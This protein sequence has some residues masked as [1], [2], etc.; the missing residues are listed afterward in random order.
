M[1]PKQSIPIFACS[2]AVA[3]LVCCFGCSYTIKIKDGQTAYAQKRYS[4]AIPLLINELA[5]T[6]LRSEKALR[7]FLIGDS[8][9]LKGEDD[10]ALQWFKKSYDSNNNPDALKAWAF[11]LK[12][13]QQYNTAKEAFKNLGVEIGSPYEYRKEITACAVA[14]DWLKQAP[15]SGYSLQTVPFNSPQNDFAPTLYAD[16]RIVFTSDRALGKGAENYAWTGNKFMDLLIVEPDEASPQ[17]FDNHLN[18]SRH[19]GTA[20]FNRTGSQVFFVRSIEAFKGNDAFCKIYFSEKNTDGAWSDP[21]PFPFQK[22]KINYL[23]PALSADGN[24]L[25]FAAN[26]PDAWGGY[27]LFYAS[28]NQFTESGWDEPQLLSRNINSTGNE[29]F[30]T[31]D[32]DTLYFASDGWT[33]MGGLDIFRTYKTDKNTWTPPQNLKAPINSGA[34]DFSFVVGHNYTNA[35]EKS[36]KPGTRLRDGF[37]SSNRPGG[38]GGDDIYRFEQVVPNPKPPQSDSTQN[39]TL[40]YKIILDVYV[41][42]KIYLTPDDPNSKILGRKPLPGSKL[43]LTF[44]SKKQQLVTPPDG[45]VRLELTEQTDYSF[46]ASMDNYLSNYAR[47]STKG[48]AKDPNNPTQIFEL[49]IVVD[50]IFRNKEIVLDNIYYDYDKWDIRPDAEPTLNKLAEVLNQNPGIRIQLGSHTDCRGNDAY[51]QELSQRRAQSA[52]EYLI[53]KGIPEERLSAKGFGESAPAVNCAC[54][55]CTESEHQ[56]NRRTTFTILE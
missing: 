53:A 1:I 30:P 46:T 12:K 16:G 8:Y 50:K 31:F 17:I 37:F 11:S 26:D 47:F 49:E 2:A 27:D 4:E 36:P 18:T 33:G 41:L 56:T 9:R 13:L 40:T 7:E 54:N 42:E 6:Q 22:E 3:L 34:D 32:K 28:R 48:I 5:N 38:K 29:L 43:T 23:H 51:N 44:G 20:C 24:T 55:R 25:F 21:I 45:P 35:N 39:K 14:E 10:N 15:Q 52:V 19:E